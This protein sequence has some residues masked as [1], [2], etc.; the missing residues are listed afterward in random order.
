MSDLHPLDVAL[1][2]AIE[3]DADWSERILRDQPADDPR[4]AFNLGWHELRHGN[5]RHGMDLMSAGRMLSVFGRSSVG[6]TRPSSC[7]RKGDWA[8][9]SSMRGLPKTCPRTG[10]WC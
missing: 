2:L 9:T 6:Q 7:A 8:T 4:V 1:K 10:G 3:G 5:L